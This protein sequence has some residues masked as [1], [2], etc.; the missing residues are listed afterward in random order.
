MLPK[1]I[2][3]QAYKDITQAYFEGIFSTEEWIEKWKAIIKHFE[4]EYGKNA[5]L[6]LGEDK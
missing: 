2:Y 4:D 6:N 5:S 3:K 1:F